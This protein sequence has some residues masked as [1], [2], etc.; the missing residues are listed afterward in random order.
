MNPKQFRLFYAWQS[1]SPTATNRDAIRAALRA[2]RKVLEPRTRIAITL[3]EATRDEAG[4]PNIPQTI[5]DK[6]RVSDAFVCDITTI[7]KSAPKGLRRM[8]NPNVVFELGY[9]VAHLGWGRIILLFN[10][11]HGTFPDDLPFD[12][13]RHRASRYR[14]ST[15]DKKNSPAHNKLAGLLVEA[16]GMIIKLR[17][18]RPTTRSS[19]D[20]LRRQ[21]DVANIK[22]LLEQVSIIALDEMINELP[23][24][25]ISKIFYFW[26]SFDSVY[27]SSLFHIHDEKLR[28]II[29]AVHRSW[30][31]CVS[32]GDDYKATSN[33]EKYVFE[34]PYDAA[35]RARLARSWKQID[36]S[37]RLLRK[38][39]DSLLS[40]LRK[41]YLDVDIDQCSSVAWK[42][43][44]DDHREA[45]QRLSLAKK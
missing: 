5:L 37:R 23:K 25:Q 21:R 32:H 13:D 26:E 10:E 11:E 35:S 43:Y 34:T 8:P 36:S 16:V 7:N 27:R 14:L 4:S 1:D 29:D 3:D 18:P 33:A 38:S 39:L 24:F 30:D 9:A 28:K 20:E 40:I 45:A 6:I 42:A 19:E 31:G 2:S 12:F 17:P 41:H 44:V 22:W 15:S